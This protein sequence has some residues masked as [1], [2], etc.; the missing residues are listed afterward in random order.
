MSDEGPDEG[1]TKAAMRD[2]ALADPGQRRPPPDRHRSTSRAF[3][4]TMRGGRIVERGR[5]ETLLAQ[6]GRYAAFRRQQ[7]KPRV[8]PQ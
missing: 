2:V 8:D 7:T 4:N 6:G 5:H 3:E 1:P